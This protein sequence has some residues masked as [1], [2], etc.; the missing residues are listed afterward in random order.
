MGAQ[1]GEECTNAHDRICQVDTKCTGRWRRETSAHA[2]GKFAEA[3]IP[4]AP[5]C[6][7][8][9]RDASGL[10]APH[11]VRQ[12]RTGSLGVHDTSSGWPSATHTHTHTQ[13]MLPWMEGSRQRQKSG[14]SHCMSAIAGQRQRNRAAHLSIIFLKGVNVLLTAVGVSAFWVRRFSFSL[15]SS[16]TLNSISGAADLRRFSGVCAQNTASVVHVIHLEG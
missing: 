13:D 2:Q 3:R 7:L 10:L 12:R 5:N 11:S 8:T 16:F 6:D 9:S 15:S 4:H 14:K 1:H